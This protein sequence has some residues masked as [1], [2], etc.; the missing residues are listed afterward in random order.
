MPKLSISIPDALWNRVLEQEGQEIRPSQLMQNVLRFYLDGTHAPE[1]FR[2]QAA[3]DPKRLRAVLDSLKVSYQERWQA[4]YEDGLT[5]VEKIGYTF[6]QTLGRSGKLRLH[7]DMLDGHPNLASEVWSHETA[8]E[9]LAAE[10][11]AHYQDNRWCG[12]F[13][14]RAVGSQYVDDRGDPAYRDGAE[15]ALQDVW[16]ALQSETTSSGEG[17]RSPDGKKATS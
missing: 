16:E 3:G 15:Q 4:G 6:F 17:S 1:G 9:K 10:E 2:P 14:F 7:E 13:L 8:I 12:R 11:F 5:F